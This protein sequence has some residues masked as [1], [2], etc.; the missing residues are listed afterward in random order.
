MS[1]LKLC[2]TLLP[3]LLFTVMQ[4][5]A[6]SEADQKKKAALEQFRSLIESKKYY[7]QANSATSMKGR[8]I[9]L[10]GGYFLRLNNDELVVYLPYYGRSFTSDYGSQNLSVDFTSRDFTYSA[11]STKKGGWEITI[12]PANE[13]KANKINLSIGSSGYTTVRIASS[14]RQPIPY[15]GQVTVIPSK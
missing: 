3:A 1:F 10:T 11:D 4:V 6:Q 8:T 13:P 5:R 12:T 9:Q 14:S 2:R 15:Y 7:F